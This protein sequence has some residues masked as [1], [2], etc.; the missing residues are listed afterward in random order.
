MASAL[1]EECKPLTTY[2]TGIPG[3]T[4]MPEL[5]VP[6]AGAEKSIGAFLSPDR[7]YVEHTG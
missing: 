5:V 7:G 1:A 3:P 4:R 6:G 2:P